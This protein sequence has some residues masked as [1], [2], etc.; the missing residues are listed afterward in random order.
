MHGRERE[1]DGGL[2]KDGGGLHGGGVLGGERGTSA[3]L[4][5]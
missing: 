2:G 3:Q 1:S 5:Y 4:L